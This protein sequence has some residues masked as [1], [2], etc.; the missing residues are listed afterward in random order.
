MAFLQGF[1]RTDGAFGSLIVRQS[2]LRDPHSGLYD[3]DLPEHV[4]LIS[5]WQ[6]EMG[7]VKFVAHLHHGGDDISPSI[8]VNGK[9]RVS[10][11]RNQLKPNERMPLATF[12]V[13]QVRSSILRKMKVNLEFQEGLFLGQTL[14]VPCYKQWDPGRSCGNVNR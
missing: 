2:R 11:P 7:L 3:Y 14:S 1:Q 6:K 9:G 8:I 4:I 12:E 13:K 10:K 5:D